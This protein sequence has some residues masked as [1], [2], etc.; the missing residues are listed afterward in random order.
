MPSGIVS[1][2]SQISEESQK[3]SQELA[4]ELANSFRSSL[5]NSLRTSLELRVRQA[6]TKRL[7]PVIPCN[8]L[9]KCVHARAFSGALSG[10][11]S[12]AISGAFAGALSGP[13]SGALSGALSGMPEGWGALHP[14]QFPYQNNFHANVNSM[15]V[16]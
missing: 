6:G 3:L 15:T 11:F 2:V 14:V 16:E 5:R 12:G 1:G 9:T 7:L 13:F 10:T 4:R 8:A